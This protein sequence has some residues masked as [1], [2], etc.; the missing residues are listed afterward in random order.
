VSEVWISPA[1]NG[2]TCEAR[3]GATIHIQLPENPTTGF[4]WAVDSVTDTF[5]E[6]QSSTYVQGQ[7]VGVGGG[8]TRTFSFRAK[9]PGAGDIKLKLWRE[10]QGDSSVVERFECAIRIKR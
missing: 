6:P 5:I 2:K 3:P 7:S 10:W 9:Q 4:R 1:D 8:G